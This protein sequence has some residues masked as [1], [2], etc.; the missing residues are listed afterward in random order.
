MRTRPGLRELPAEDR[1]QGREPTSAGLDGKPSFMRRTA[2]FLLGLTISVVVHA[3]PGYAQDAEPE[4][5]PEPVKYEI[6]AEAVQKDVELVMD[7]TDEAPVWTGSMP[8]LSIS[9][10]N[11]SESTRHTVVMPGDGSMVGWRE[12]HIRYEVERYGA[13]GEPVAVEAQRIMRCGN[14]DANWLDE[15]K[16]LEPGDAVEFE[17]YGPI[18]WIHDLARPGRYRIRGLYSFSRRSS[19]ASQ[20]SGDPDAPEEL[21][22]MD[23][24]APY[25]LK[26]E[27]VEWTAIEPVRVTIVRTG[28]VVFGSTQMASEVIVAHV[29]NVSAETLTI[30]PDQVRVSV[31]FTKKTGN[32]TLSADARETAPRGP[33]VLEPGGQIA[34]FGPNG[35]TS[36]ELAIVP[37]REAGEPTEP[38]ES[39]ESAESA[40]GEFDYRVSLSFEAQKTVIAKSAPATLRVVPAR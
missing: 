28:T 9:L 35:L 40:S 4:P 38:G 31:E 37:R 20:W 2:F 21:G 8:A 6:S 23:A 25:D 3:A 39:V 1:V 18:T 17:H 30:Q 33:I 14:Y 12:P 19:R 27:W 16:T 36:T 7:R 24:Y 34:L 32:L 10:R 15:L 29:E 22:S 5:T 11:R 13:D 26:S